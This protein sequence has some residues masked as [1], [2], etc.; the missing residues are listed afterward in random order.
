MFTIQVELNQYRRALVDKMVKTTR[1]FF[2]NPHFIH[3]FLVFRACPTSL[4]ELGYGHYCRGRCH[5]DYR[6][7]YDEAYEH[8]EL[9]SRGSRSKE[10]EGQNSPPVRHRK[11]VPR[12]LVLQSWSAFYLHDEVPGIDSRGLCRGT[13]VRKNLYKRRLTLASHGRLAHIPCEQGIVVTENL[14]PS[15]DFV[16]GRISATHQRFCLNGRKNKGAPVLPRSVVCKCY[17]N[18]Y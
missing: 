3:I 6:Y 2:Y 14:E 10:S 9:L 8:G 1:I 18:F 13:A 5:Y 7:D 4:H 12:T 15:R 11:S 17:K 16:R